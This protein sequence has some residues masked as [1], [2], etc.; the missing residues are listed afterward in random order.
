MA[1][2]A[3]PTQPSA[4]SDSA[5]CRYATAYLLDSITLA[6]TGAPNTGAARLIVDGS[7]S[8]VP[9]R[10]AGAKCDPEEAQV[11]PGPARRR[12]AYTAERFRTFPYGYARIVL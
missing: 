12:G 5:I 4:V 9:C 2:R 1:L 7:K 8:L 10:V 6:V 3:H 11:D